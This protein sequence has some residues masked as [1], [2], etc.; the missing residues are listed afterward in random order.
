MNRQD[1]IDL[2]KRLG[3]EA[4]ERGIGSLNEDQ[5]NVLVPYWAHGV[6]ENGGFKYLLE[7]SYDLIDVAR[8]FR[9]LGFPDVGNAC[10]EVARSV[11]GERT[12]PDPSDR[13]AI[14]SRVDWD[15]FQPQEAVVFRVSSD[16]L[17]DSIAAYVSA[18]PDAA[19]R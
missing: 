6:I 11:L 4:D 2:M 19:A 9:A 3:R 18:H 5:R 16:A 12:N 14:L 17:K 10:E 1:T 8:R 7:W 13:A 15:A